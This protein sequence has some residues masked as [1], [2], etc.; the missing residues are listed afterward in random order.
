MAGSSTI[1][2][3]QSQTYGKRQILK[4]MKKSTL[5]Q[6]MVVASTLPRTI[7]EYTDKQ[8]ITGSQ[9]REMGITSIQ[10]KEV[11]LTDRYPTEV[12][13]TREVQ[14]FSR[15][16][17][18]YKRHGPASYLKEYRTWLDIRFIKWIKKIFK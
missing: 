14:H 12:T 2:C 6:L 7:E 5:H 17:K 10:G 1:I 13:M 9:L 8:I 3:R 18:Y 16:K 11:M 4:T 15:L